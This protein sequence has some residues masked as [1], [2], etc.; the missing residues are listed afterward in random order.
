VAVTKSN[1]SKPKPP[2]HPAKGQQFFVQTG[3]HWSIGVNHAVR[4]VSSKS[5]FVYSNG[6]LTRHQLS[7]WQPWLQAR[8][9]EGKLIYLGKELQA[10][11][12]FQ[13]GMSYR[14]DDAGRF[15]RDQ[16]FLR[17]STSVLDKYKFV[18][19][20]DDMQTVHFDIHGGD[21]VYRVSVPRADQQRL[22]CSCPDSKRF[23][24][25][26]D[27]FCKHLVAVLMSNQDLRFHLLEALL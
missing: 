10:P 24:K 6:Q 16:R 17:A 26:P 25:S 1:Q 20:D 4:K 23:S 7:Q 21:K 8:F 13:T 3:K 14:L 9:S 12:S 2:A 5:F 11:R 27:Q 18:R 15:A 22:T 19:E